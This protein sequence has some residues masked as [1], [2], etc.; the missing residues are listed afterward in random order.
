MSEAGRGRPWQHPKRLALLYTLLATALLLPLW[1]ASLRWYESQL[2]VGARAQMAEQIALQSTALSAAINRRFALVQGLHAFVQAQ[3]TSL[4]LDARFEEFAAGLYNNV[5]NNADTGI[6]RNI[7]VAPGGTVRYVYPPAGNERLMGY[8]AFQDPRPTV[9][10]ELARALDSRAIILSAPSQ[11]MEG[12]VGL[13]ARQA[14]Y[15][16]DAFWGLVSLTLNVTPFFAEA[17]MLDP[18]HNLSLALRD[19]E[20]QIFIGLPA[21]FERQPVISQIDLPEGSWQLAGVPVQGWQALIAVPLRLFGAAGLMIVVLLAGLTYLSVNRQARLALAV[22]QRTEDLWRANAELQASHEGLERRVAERTRELSSLLLMT[23]VVGST[24]NRDEVLDRILDQLQRVVRYDS[25]S[26]QELQ[27][28]QLAVIA[29]RGFAQPNQWVGLVFALDGETPNGQ[30]ITG[31]TVLNLAD[32]PALYGSFRQPPHSHIRS[33]LGVPLRVQERIVGMITLDRVE[34]GGFAAQEV[35]MAVAFADQAALALENARLY[36]Q[37][38]QVA[39]LEERQRIAR[40][41]HDS[42]SQTLYG[43]GLGARTAREAL[44]ETP[45]EAAESIDYVLALAEAGLAEMR[46][47]LL[48]LRPEAL[49]QEGLAAALAKQAEA[50]R[51]RHQIAV[52]TDIGA[53]PAIPSE[54]KAML[55]RVAQEALH[56]IAKHAHANAVTVRLAGT[57]GAVVLEVTDNGVGFDPNGDFPGHWGLRS[58]RERMDRLGGALQIDSAAGAGTR[59]QA[60]LPQPAA[61]PFPRQNLPH[62]S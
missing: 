62:T 54:A 59:I 11:L 4:E 41:L 49:E 8:V 32:A 10:A 29:G 37:V 53:E 20:G 48:E 60:L 39:V 42:V 12:G 56:N 31:Q 50:L 51:V 3:P 52:Q 34:P 23:S 19:Q 9:R 1:L 15:V 55:Y 30:V 36:A 57:P 7:T 43:I 35:R 27:G 38:E 58:M 61:S 28:E 33:W 16:E 26:V 18:D 13:V 17:G 6:L 5:G 24:L 47:L 40:E 25:A 14:I 21:V 45:D 22:R 2:L 46:S 44:A